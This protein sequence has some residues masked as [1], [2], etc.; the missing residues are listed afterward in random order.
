MIEIAL[1]IAISVIAIHYTYQ[2]KEIFGFVNKWGDKHIPKK[3][4]SPLYA[5]PACMCPW[6]GS[7][8]YLIA[9]NL[10]IETFGDARWFVIFFTT[11]IALGI[12]AVYVKFVEMVDK[13]KNYCSK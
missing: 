13:T 6:Y 5:C 8:I 12:N 7:I 10:N 4:Q 11:I 9:H 2:E 3:L 1:I